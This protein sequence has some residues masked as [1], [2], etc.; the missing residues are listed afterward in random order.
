MFIVTE[1][2]ALS[3]IHINRI[4]QADKTQAPSP[5]PRPQGDHAHY[6]THMLNLLFQHW[7]NISL[8]GNIQTKSKK[9]YV[10]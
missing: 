4:E 7:T 3:Q 10:V 6:V 2:A 5:N 1:Y 9:R 8:E